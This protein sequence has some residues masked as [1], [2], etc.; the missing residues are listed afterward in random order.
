L[1]ARTPV[2]LSGDFS[3][4]PLIS[5]GAGSP[6]VFLH[7]PSGQEWPGYLD[8]LAARYR[9][10]APAHPGVE[11]PSDLALLNQLWDLVLYYDELFEALGLGQIDLIGHCFGGMVAAEIAATYPARVRRLVLL[12]ARG[13]WRADAPVGEHVTAPGE[14][15]DHRRLSAA[16]AT[17]HFIRPHP[18]R[19]LAN[20]LHRVRARTLVLWGARDDVVPPVY[21][22]EF[23]RRIR[24]ARVEILAGAGH[25]PHREQRAEVSRHTLRFLS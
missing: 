15:L 24:D 25:Y 4:N 7:G 22:E 23:G 14:Q 3:P 12:D 16:A 18:E 10:Y 2:A 17:A 13:L 9:V 6:V 11:N 8:D 1:P 21:A 5:K 19:G 20:C